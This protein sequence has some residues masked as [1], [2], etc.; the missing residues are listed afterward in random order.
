MMSSTNS[1][2]Y[3]LEFEVRSNDNGVLIYFNWTKWV[4]QVVLHYL[5]LHANTTFSDN[6]ISST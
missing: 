3:E 5:I 2:G 6:N 1:A 4:V